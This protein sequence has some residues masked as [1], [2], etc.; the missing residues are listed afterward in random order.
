MVKLKILSWYFHTSALFS[1]YPSRAKFHEKYPL[2]F[3]AIFTCTLDRQM[4]TSTE[5]GDNRHSSSMS[6]SLFPGWSSIPNGNHCT[7][8]VDIFFHAKVCET[9][10]EVSIW[11][12]NSE[13]T[14]CFAICNKKKDMLLL[15][16]RH[17][18]FL[19]CETSS[20]SQGN[21]YCTKH[22][23]E[24]CIQIKIPQFWVLRKPPKI[25]LGLHFFLEKSVI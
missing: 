20:I 13:V 18:H 16:L 4:Q 15:T 17:S 19:P 7:H 2:L 22:D 6:K 25:H 10:E 24:S 23:M 14:H 11:N 9:T 12:W 1:I 5:G 21:F 8:H 3:E